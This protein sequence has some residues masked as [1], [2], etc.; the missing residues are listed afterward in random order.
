MWQLFPIQLMMVF[1]QSLLQYE[2]LYCLTETLQVILER[3]ESTIL[4]TVPTEISS[5]SEI[6]AIVSLQFVKMSALTESPNSGVLIIV[7]L[8]SLYWILFQSSLINLAYM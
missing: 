7:D 1:T 5:F 3:S 4:G 8:P 6:S 2:A